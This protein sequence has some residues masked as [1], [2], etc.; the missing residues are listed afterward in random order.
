[1]QITE[2]N[3]TDEFKQKPKA[4]QELINQALYILDALGVPLANLSGRRL[5]RTAMAFLAVADVKSTGNWPELKDVT[6]NRSLRT[7]DIIAYVNTNFLE[8][9]SMGSYDDIR[10][11]DLSLSVAAG[12]VIQT[13]PN[14]ARNNSM[15]GYAISSEFAEV[16]RTFRVADWYE[17]K[18]FMENRPTLSSKLSTPREITRTTVTLPSGVVLDFSPGQHNVLQ[19]AIIEEFLPRYGYNAEVLYVGD[20]AKKFLVLEKEKLEEL[21]FFELAHG[22]LPDIIAYSA[23]RNWLYL[24]EAFFSSGPISPMRLLKLKNLTK[25]CTAGM[26]YVTAFLTR[27]AFRGQIANI[28]WETEVW[29]AADPDHLIHFDGEKFLGPF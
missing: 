11:K 29:I 9:I 14:S 5:E 24:I 22:E 16:I 1:M 13:S 7:R 15:R 17:P 4:T 27:D 21:R 28:A 20:A 19:K 8:N 23:E 12:V 26:I 25:S 2:A 10:R 3:A 18:K 6:S